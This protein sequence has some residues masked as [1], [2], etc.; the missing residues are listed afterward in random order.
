VLYESEIKKIKIEIED[1]T[2][3]PQEQPAHSIH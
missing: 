3:D 1:V 2:E